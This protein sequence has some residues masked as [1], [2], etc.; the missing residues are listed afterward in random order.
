MRLA[1]LI[2]ATICAAPVAAADQVNM[3]VECGSGDELR[4]MLKEYQESAI[5]VMSSNRRQGR[6]AVEIP[7]V[8]FVN[9]ETQTWSLVE[10]L[11]DDVYCVVAQGEQIR[12][13]RS[14]GGI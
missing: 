4:A 13:H 2:T 1:A 10:Q 3:P 8:L 6:Q 5:L 14:P 9:T 12:G 7:A 11:D